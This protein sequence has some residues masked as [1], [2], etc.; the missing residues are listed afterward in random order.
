MRVTV[1]RHSYGAPGIR[2]RHVGECTTENCYTTHASTCDP[3]LRQDFCETGRRWV[4][5]KNDPGVTYILDVH[6]RIMG[7]SHA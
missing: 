6:N 3:C 5:E 7:D 4:V 2:S 1:D